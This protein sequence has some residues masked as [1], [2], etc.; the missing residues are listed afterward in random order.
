MAGYTL[1]IAEAEPIWGDSRVDGG[2]GA[3]GLVGNGVIPGD[4]KRIERLLGEAKA[5]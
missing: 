2:S 3:R 4:A 1:W 5:E